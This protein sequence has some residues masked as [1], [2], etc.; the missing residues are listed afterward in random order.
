MTRIYNYSQRS[1]IDAYNEDVDDII[2]VRDIKFSDAAREWAD[3][4]ELYI[5]SPTQ[6]E[7]EEKFR[8]W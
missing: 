4:V 8:E 6:E 1:I 5:P 2:A 3:G 7:N